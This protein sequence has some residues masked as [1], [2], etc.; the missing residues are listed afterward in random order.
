MIGIV[1]YGLGNLASVANALNY[2]NQ[3]V[4]QVTKPS[5]VKGVNALILP[6]VGHFGAGM[7]N[8]ARSG[9]A[10]TLNEV[11]LNNNMPILGICLG[12]Q[13]MF[14]GSDEAPGVKGL[15]WFEAK[16]KILKSSIL[17]TPNIGWSDVRFRGRSILLD[18][19][20]N[21]TFYFVHSYYA[22]DNF[23][24]VTS[25]INADIKVSSSIERD[26]I[27]AVQFH[28]EKSQRDGIKLITNFTKYVKNG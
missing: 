27:F 2:L 23:T 13:L 6:G 19:L 16:C 1:D 25:Y 28:P 4:R 3:S 20:D 5:D 26:N 17:R 24:G 22:E 12:M 14:A 15:G 11:V 10:D 9:L 18:G 21:P 7:Q 8:L